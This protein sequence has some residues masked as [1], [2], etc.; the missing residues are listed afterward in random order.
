[1]L[2][3]VNND[4]HSHEKSN[5]SIIRAKNIF[6]NVKMKYEL[7]LYYFNKTIRFR[8]GLFDFWICPFGALLEDLKLD[9]F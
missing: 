1:M 5:I 4:Q 8:L 3:V 2:K 9:L 6:I 7:T